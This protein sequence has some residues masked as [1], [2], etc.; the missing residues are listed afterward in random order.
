MTQQKLLKSKDKELKELLE[1]DI[2]S[3]TRADVKNAEDH[4]KKQEAIVE[5]NDPS[6]PR[7]N[8]KFI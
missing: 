7:L 1:N 8:C 6:K 2:I 4:F 5:S 3:I